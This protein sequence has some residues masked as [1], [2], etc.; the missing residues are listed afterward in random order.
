ML[1]AI[2]IIIQLPKAIKTLKNS[3]KIKTSK[4][5]GKSIN[6]VKTLTEKYLQPTW[7]YDLT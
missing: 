7:I 2:L 5:G 1:E 3:R 4:W 6:N